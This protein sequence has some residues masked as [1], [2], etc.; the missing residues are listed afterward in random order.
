MHRT[1]ALRVVLAGALMTVM[2]VAPV[3]AATPQPFFQGF[4]TDTAGWDGATRVMTGMLGV[5]SHSGSW[6]AQAPLGSSTFTRWGGYTNEFPDGG[7]TTAVWVYLDMS[8]TVNDTRFDWSSAV[9]TPADPPQHRR[10]FVFNGGFYND[11][12]VTGSGPRFVFTGS[13]NAGR[14]SSFPKNPARDP[15]TITATGWY[16]FRHVFSDNG[17]VLSVDLQI[18]SSS[19]AVLNTWTLSDPTDI[20]GSTVGG[21]RYGWFVIHEFAV[22]AFDDSRLDVRVGPPSNKDDCKDGGWQTF[23]FPQEFNNQGDCIQFFNTGM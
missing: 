19:G 2:A 10:D 14:D 4:E 18:L 20:I 5:P 13:N 11:S 1:R 3:A 16:E 23:N 8:T 6:H 12:D 7:Y 17:G 9:S 21:N 22:F 15:L